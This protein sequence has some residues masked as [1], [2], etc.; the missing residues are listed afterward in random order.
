MTNAFVSLSKEAGD[1][2]LADVGGHEYVGG[3]K[4]DQQ[5]VDGSVA[6]SLFGQLEIE[7][8][9]EIFAFS[10][11]KCRLPTSATLFHETNKASVSTPVL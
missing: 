6:L 2:P 9:S 1:Q 11:A 3:I 5:K 8:A 7:R 4:R 10:P